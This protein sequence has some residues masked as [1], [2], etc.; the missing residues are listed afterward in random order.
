MRLR[1]RGIAV[2]TD[3]RTRQPSCPVAAA[4]SWMGN[5]GLGDMDLQM[6]WRLKVLAAADGWR[7]MPPAFGRHDYGLLMA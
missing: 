7:N 1:G 3:R 4:A 6:L 5:W 2:S